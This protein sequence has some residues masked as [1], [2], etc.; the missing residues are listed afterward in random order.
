MGAIRTPI[1]DE[2][3]ARI[4][5]NSGA[6]WA[7]KTP[8]LS[9]P[10]QTLFQIG[11]ELL[12]EPDIG[13]L[14]CQAIDRAIEVSGAENGLI[15]L[16]D[17]SG[18]TLFEAARNLQREDIKNPVFEVCQTI[19]HRV[20][21]EGTP[22]CLR[23]AL[24]AAWLQQS[25]SVVRLKIL[26]VACLPLYQNEKVFGVVYL[27]NRTVRGAFEPN[28]CAFLKEFADFI[29]LAAFRAL[30]LKRAQNHQ[31]ALEDELRARYDFDAIVGHSPKMIKILHLVSQVSDTNAPVLIE[32][33]S[34]SGKELVARA[35]HYNSR[36]R[37]MPIVSINCGPF[38]R[39]CWNPSC[40]AMKEARLPAL[41]KGAKACL[42][43]RMAARC[44]WTK[45]KR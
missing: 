2:N 23:D 18:K 20:R 35:I 37:A 36:R 13:H 34:G 12:R 44:F 17:G 39:A 24:E 3:P 9:A 8:G 22:I 25:D 41:S 6:W 32:G 31:Y 42:N 4:E 30:E 19:L 33:E 21:T 43:K 15:I 11:K 40:L 10:Y 1:T 14:L 16:F 27:D 29:A 45:W 28:I 5:E 26:S 7:E 38:R